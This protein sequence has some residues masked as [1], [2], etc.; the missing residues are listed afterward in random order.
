MTEPMRRPDPAHDDA[1][2]LLPAWLSATVPPLYAT[3][4]LADPTIYV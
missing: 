1:H 4:G 3:D 2:N